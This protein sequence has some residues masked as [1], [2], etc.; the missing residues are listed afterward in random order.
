MVDVAPRTIRRLWPALLAGVVL[1][2]VVALGAAVLA[3]MAPPPDPNVAAVRA[4]AVDTLVMEHRMGIRDASLTSL[5]STADAA[6]LHAAS[7]PLEVFLPTADALKSLQAEMPRGRAM[8]FLHEK[9]DPGLKGVY[10]L[11]GET[12]S[13]FLD[14]DGRPTAP[15]ND[16]S[17]LAA[18]VKGAW[19]FDALASKVESL[20]ATP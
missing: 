7:V 18:E 19:T 16:E 4:L 15:S 3:A 10:R 1:V 9:Q 13:Y 8:F 14:S 5:I 20:A 11:V 2:V 17:T 12:A 6:R